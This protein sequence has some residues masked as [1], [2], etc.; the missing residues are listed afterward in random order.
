MSIALHR[1]TDVV[2]PPHSRVA[3]VYPSMDLYDAYSIELPDQASG[4]PETLAR[5]VFARSPAWI[6]GLM[7]VRDALVAGLGLKTARRLH[8]LGANGGERVGMFRIYERQPLEIVLGE[9]DKHLD[10]KLSV[11]CQPPGEAVAR[12]RLIVSTAVHCHNRLGRAY[13]AAIAPFHRLIVRSCLRHA[14]RIGWP[15]RQ[16]A[17]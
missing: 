9:D 5:F 7:R 14:A 11:L 13:I 17:D 15:P 2:P 6:G 10:F 3:G 8:R 4:D 12:R 16:S 1:V